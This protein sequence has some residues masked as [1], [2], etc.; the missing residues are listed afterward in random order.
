MKTYIY[1]L[2]LLFSFAL[3][4]QVT[5]YEKSGKTK[6][7]TYQ[8]CVSWY[9]SFTNTY[10]EFVMDSIGR[11]DNGDMIY[12]CRYADSDPNIE[13]VKMLVNNNIHPGEPEGVDA[14]ML[15][16]K[17]LVS[18]RRWQPILKRVGLTIICQ[19]N[20]GGTINRSCCSRANQNGPLEVGFRG[21]AKNLDLNRDFIKMD[22]RNARNFVQ[23][24][25]DSKFDILVDNHTSNGAD[26]QYVL[27]SF[28]SRPEKL[29]RN[30]RG[31]AQKLENKVS[32]KLFEKGWP[33]APYVQ[34]LKTTP[35]NGIVA[36]WES[37]RYAT[38]FAGLH[39]C[40][41]FTVETHMLKP[42][43]ERVEATKAY[44]EQMMMAVASH[45]E[46][47]RAAKKE[48]RSRRNGIKKIY[49]HWKLD[50]FNYDN[51]DFLG[52]KSGYKKSKVTGKERLYY[53]RN[54]PVKMT[55]PYFSHYYPIDS[56]SI[57]SVYIIPSAWES[58]I[59]KLK[60][61]GVRLKKV[62]MDT[63]MLVKAKYI[64]SYETVSSP[65]EGHYLHY[66]IK[67][68]DTL[69]YRNIR[70]TDYI[71]NTRQE[72]AQFISLALEPESPDSYFAWNEFDGILMQKEGF[73]SYVFED[74]AEKLLSEDATL[75]Q[76]FLNKKSRDPEFAANSRAQLDFIYKRSNYYEPTHNLYPIYSLDL[77]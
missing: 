13:S 28:V 35:D 57:P 25:T 54:Q 1:I 2:G 17:E 39:H 8:E 47:I 36:F 68:R 46:E 19:Y 49:P 55:I 38:G 20:V 52:F 50:T 53:D 33:N 22:S 41:G 75:E 24:F 60:L 18:D 3:E 71:V 70:R 66:N 51:I 31:I 23:F 5:P 40:I 7:A 62:A 72:L 29:H 16:L 56:I 42:F 67:T 32:E 58:V 37:G 44:M 77:K 9:R 65:Y 21:N 63:T 6:T 45:S 74:L 15:F 48:A 69:I 26:Y 10:K 61:N 59:Q 11:G 73:S 27:T 14:S 4:A 12:I 76:A 30:L 64:E 43:A 34:S